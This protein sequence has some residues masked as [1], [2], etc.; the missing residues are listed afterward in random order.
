MKKSFSIALTGLAALTIATACSRGS[1]WTLEGKIDNAPEGVLTVEGTNAAGRWYVIDTIALDSDGSFDYSSEA[2]SYPEIFRL[3]LNGRHIYFPVDSID[4]ITIEADGKAFDSSYT[5]GGSHS[6]TAFNTVDSL[7]NA[8]GVNHQAVDIDTASNL[9]RQLGELI[10]DN[11]GGIVAYYVVNKHFRGRPIFRLDNR[12]ELGMIGAVA[13]A[14][15]EYCPANPRTEYLRNL[16]LASRNQFS[17]RTDTIEAREMTMVEV[18]LPDVT[19]KSR[20]LSDVVGANHVTVVS[21]ASYKDKYAQPLTLALRE[22]YDK[23]HTQ[24]FEVYQIG[25][26]TSEFD[27]R[28]SAQNLPWITV[29]NGLTQQNLMN[30]NVGSL[31][32]MFVYV[33]GN[34]SKRLESVD[35][36]KKTVSS[37]F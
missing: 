28:I 3:N 20:R 7:L 22:L 5:L 31:P 10:L 16:W 12:R 36:L 26:D 25:F 4:R 23:Y 21:F 17:S 15:T 30:Y 6:A 29:F 24:G 32:A 37:N 13:N 33:D 2:P 34:L 8:F 1:E 9:K 19:G 11:P 14:Y 18:E 35:D 27:W